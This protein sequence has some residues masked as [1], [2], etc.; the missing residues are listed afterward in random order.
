MFLDT[1]HDVDTAVGLA[2][3][4][5]ERIFLISYNYNWSYYF[6]L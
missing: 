4:Q 6:R 2:I 1:V 3:L 5:L